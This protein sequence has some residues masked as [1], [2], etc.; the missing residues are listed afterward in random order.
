MEYCL[1]SCSYKL[2]CVCYFDNLL[3]KLALFKCLLADRAMTTAYELGLDQILHDLKADHK[4]SLGAL[5]ISIYTLGYCIGPLIVAPLSEIYGRIWLLRVAYLVFP[6]TLVGCG[7][8]RSI[9]A[10]IVFR[11]IMGFAGIVFLL[12]GAAIIPD[13]MP[14]ERRG[15]SLGTMLTGAGLVS[16]AVFLIIAIHICYKEGMF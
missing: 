9:G 2:C 6:L 5:S 8:S 10:L 7:A 16:L 14:K 13:I 1:H 12:L 15:I 3:P 4:D 11:A